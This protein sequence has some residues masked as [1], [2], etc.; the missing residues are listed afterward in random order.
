MPRLR[1]ILLGL[2]LVAL[3]GWSGNSSLEVA[4]AQINPAPG[5]NRNPAGN[6]LGLTLADRELVKRLRTAKLLLTMLLFVLGRAQ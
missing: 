3:A 4:M 5:L 6:S 2:G 1:L